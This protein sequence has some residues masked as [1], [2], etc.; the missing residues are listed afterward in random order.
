MAGGYNG[1]LLWVNLSDG[2]LSTEELSELFC[3]RYLGGA[4]FVSYYLLKEVKRG[5]DPLGPDNKLIFALGPVTGAALPGSGRNCIGAKSPL[6][7]GFAKAEVGGFW[8]AELKRA[9]YD[10]I[11]V[12]GKAERPVYLRIHDGEASLHDAGHLWGKSPKEAQNSLR[13]ELGDE[14]I[15]VAAIGIGGENQVRYA[16]I[17]N[18]L[19]NFA[20]RGG[21]GAVMGS[22][23]LKAIAVRGH[24]MPA[25]AQPEKLKEYRT[26]LLENITL[27]EGFR[28]YG[29]GGAMER[30]E[31]NGNLPIHNFRDGVF[32]DA[33][34]ISARTIK[35]TIRTGMEGCFACPVRCKKVIEFTEP[36]PVDPDYGGPEYETLAALGSNCGVGDLKAL[37][38]ANELCSAYTL[39]TISVGGTIAFAM[40]C[41]EKGLL[42]TGD[43][44]GIELK[45]GNVD[46]MLEMIDRI[47]RRKGIGELLAQGTARMAQEIGGGS[48]AFAMGVK[49]LEAG[50]HEPR[51][52]AGLGLGFALH[53]SGADHCGAMHDE[54]FSAEGRDLERMK[55]LGILEPV[56]AD[57]LGPRKVS[58]L[59]YIQQGRSIGD[60]LVL[61]SFFPYD[62]QQVA[63]IISAVTGWNTGV[64]EMMTTGRRILTLARLFNTREGFTASDDRLPARFFSPKTG[65]ALSK[66][67]ID[68]EKLEK[69][70][71]YYYLL[72]G[73]DRETGVPLPETLEELDIP[74]AVEEARA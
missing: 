15:R 45:F 22:K 51:L 18:D 3:R 69:A 11:I 59:R 54:L 25:V 64:V 56:P 6:T 17:A 74:W 43:T 5:I 9:G 46:A 57:D 48:Q 52:K 4:G 31:A 32:P 55:S 20:G 37:A 41:F 61:C 16:C 50:M 39:D 1:K 58:L 24:K 60:S 23:N 28:K 19:R 40:E 13:A 72:M 42:T 49:G 26:W 29:T 12:E 2:S 27:M 44:D 8:G 47:A 10:A 35:D 65:G 21:L 34:L 7:G 71:H 30:F 63:G 68:P 67:A 14:R 70:K 38:K 62:Y 33:K 53:P 73:W 66:S 36:Y